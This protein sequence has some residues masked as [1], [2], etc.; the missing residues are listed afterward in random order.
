MLNADDPLVADLGRDREDVTYFGVADDSQALPGLQHAADSKHCRRCGHPYEYEAVYLGHLGRYRCP[1]CGNARPA[2]SVAATRVH[3]DGMRGLGAHPE[4]TP[5][6]EIEVKL[7]IPGLYNVYNALAAA[8]AGLALGAS[9][10]AVRQGLEEFAGAFGRVETIE[11]GGRPVSILLVK[12][13]AGANEVL[14]TLTLED[15]QIDLWLALNDG[16]ADGRDVSWVWDADFEVLAGRVARVTCSGTRA[17]EMAVRLKYAGIDAGAGDRARPARLTRRRGGRRLGAAVRATHLHRAARAARGP[18]AAGAGGAV[19]GM[20]E[21]VVWHDVECAA[22]EADLP[23]WE[24]L[25]A[26][27]AAPRHRGGHGAGRAPSRARRRGCDGHR[28]GPGARRCPLP[29]CTDRGPADPR[30]LRRCAQLRARPSSSPSRSCRCRWCSC[31]AAPRGAPRCSRPYAATSHPAAC[32]RWPWRTPS[33]TP[34]T[35]PST[36]RP[37][38]TCAS[39]TA[40]CS[41]RARCSCGWSSTG[42][43]STG[44]GSA[45]RPTG[46]S[47]SRP[48]RSCSTASTRARSSARGSR[49]GSGWRPASDPGH[50]GLRRLRRR[51]AGGGVTGPALR[52]CALY[53]DL[54]N[55]YADR[56]NIAVLRARCEWRG[57]GFALG[58]AGMGESLD[59]GAWDLFY[60]GGG[61]DR[62][63]AMVAEDMVETK[64]DALHA[65]ADR[66]A[67][68]LAVCGGY[69]LLGSSYALGERRAARRRPRRPAH[70]ALGAGRA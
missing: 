38:P 61:Q 10:E 52:V 60:I 34:R 7:P 37:C 54:M 44:C 24:E 3:L 30:A 46:P 67:V 53:P 55:I 66:G 32:W 21:T 1:N 12:N 47:P 19:V 43:R 16:I 20:N 42:R 11:V 29:P 25:A 14:R 22:Y 36:P 5:A 69:Q 51:R 15:G 58:A 65:A 70:R 27:R 33:T 31:S 49:T 23:L 2:P 45:W 56:G 57:I 59:P 64:R 35:P 8:A 4:R 68:V 63:Q 48:T 50:R 17:E 28:R 18:R 40:G 39:R 6:G 26:A 41:N 9:L 62:D 13:P